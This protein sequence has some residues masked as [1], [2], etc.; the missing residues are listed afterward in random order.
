M[1]Y[2]KGL[3][4]RIDEIVDGWEGYEKKRMFADLL[5]AVR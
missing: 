4:A 5:S 1:A 2:D 3:E